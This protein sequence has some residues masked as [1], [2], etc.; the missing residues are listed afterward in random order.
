MSSLYHRVLEPTVITTGYKTPK[1]DVLD[2]GAFTRGEL[3]FRRLKDGT[4]AATY[5]RV[6]H[7]AV[8][9][10]DAF[11]DAKDPSGADLQVVL[12]NSAAG[13]K[14]MWCENFLRFIRLVAVGTVTGSPVV[15]ADSV[16][17]E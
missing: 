7:A 4:S 2:A 14:H 6:Q 8:N 3:Q 10:D 9:E 15:L 5:L 11:I 16:W 13:N 12:D 17:K 1:E